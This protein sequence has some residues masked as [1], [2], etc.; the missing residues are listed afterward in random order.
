MARM[1][2]GPGLGGLVRVGAQFHLLGLASLL[3]IVAET[4]TRPRD[5][6]GEGPSRPSSLPFT[7]L[8]SPRKD[9][10]V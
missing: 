2:V 9:V 10:Q 6:V 5:R 8:F 4:R 1:K 7:T 3:G